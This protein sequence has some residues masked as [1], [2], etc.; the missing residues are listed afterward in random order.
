MSDYTITVEPTNA[1]LIGFTLF[2]LAFIIWW[3]VI[4]RYKQRRNGN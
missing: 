2:M 3:S 4:H 1:S